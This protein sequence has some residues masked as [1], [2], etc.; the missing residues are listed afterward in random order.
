MG[1][2]AS[3]YSGGRSSSYDNYK[4]SLHTGDIVLFCGSGWQSALIQMGT[5]SPWS[6]VGMVVKTSIFND[7]EGSDPDG[8]YLWHSLDRRVY[9]CPD[10]LG[11]PRSIR[12]G[13]QLISLSRSL[14]AYRGFYYVRRLSSGALDYLKHSRQ[15]QE[16]TMEFM[17]SAVM[18][19][20]E[21]NLNELVYAAYD[22][23][24][25]ENYKEDGASY[26]C[27]E[28]VAR[29]YQEMGL[30]DSGKNAKYANEFTP[31]DFSSGKQIEFLDDSIFLDKEV[32]ID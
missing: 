13:P 6:H 24:G 9:R 31:A 29:T 11:K 23:P 28:L 4:G 26:F 16:Q 20:Y 10:M 18:R 21:I 32:K 22:G 17:R 8:L 19:H 7:Q 25:G 12:D 5:L 1:L 2:T 27:S 3:A 30:I 14:K 15:R